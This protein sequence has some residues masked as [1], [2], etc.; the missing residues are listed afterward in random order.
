MPENNQNLTQ[1]Q[2][3]EGL[4]E[5]TDEVL[6]PAVE[7]IIDDKLE[8]KLEEKIAPIHQRLNAIEE[9]LAD[10]KQRL[11]RIDK[12]SDEDVTATYQEIA[13]LKQRVC[14]LENQVKMLKAESA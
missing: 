3:K 1:Q 2:F 7:K 13:K 11:D 5:F 4:A 8:E 10:I 6:L 12:R 14:E 9:E